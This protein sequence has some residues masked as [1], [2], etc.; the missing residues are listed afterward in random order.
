[1]PGRH[2]TAQQMRLF[3]TLRQTQ[4]VPVAAAKAGL[5]QAT[6][7]RMQANPVQP[8]HKKAPRGRRRP[9]PLSDIFDTEVLP[10][11]KSSPGLRPV[12][13]FEELLR[14][15][16]ALS[17]GIRRTLE[18]RIR[19][20]RAQ[21]GP[22]QEVIFRQIHVPGKMGLS[23]FT[24]MNKHGVSIAGQ[25]LEH[26]LYHFRLAYS[27]F[28]HAHVVLG[29]E[30]YVA[31]AEG[32]QNALWSL[33]GAPAEHRTDSLSA[34][35]KNREQSAQDDLTDRVDALCG[36]YGMTPSRNT[37]GVAHENGAIEGPHGHLKR[38]IDDALIMRGSRDF[39]DL[40]GYRRFIDEIVGR[41][42]ARNAKRIDV[43]RASLKPLPA[44]RTTDYEEVTVRVTSSGGFLLRKVFYTVP[45]RLIGHQL[46]V[47]I[48]DDRLDLFLGATFLATLPR[49]R[50]TRR[51]PHQHV[52]NY[53]HVI[54]SL[55]KKPMALMGLVYRDQLFPRQAFR[56]IFAAMLEQTSER[57]A[58][59]MAVDLLALAHDR[60]CEAELAAQIEEDLRQQRLPNI[61]ALTALFA[62]SPDSLPGVEVH[63]ADLSAYDQLLG[64]TPMTLEAAA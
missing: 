35:F 10:L 55:R 27:G 2:I 23:D 34:A 59:R 38:A 21:H 26:R 1:M 48:Y 44:R 13:I 6:G 4:P 20:W 29:G 53:H 17:A 5:S 25:P 7:Y 22:E 42:N 32:L 9:D 8:S 31:L 45:S 62:P 52:V 33:G 50:A 49:A 43:E 41:I 54:H 3:M 61:A 46:R 63:L 28:E 16:P 19:A 58:C 24:D 15:Y 47:R 30:S 64:N 57:E 40:A 36:H 37:K 39:E 51:G 12:A 18:R 14:R 11:L 60:G 56:D